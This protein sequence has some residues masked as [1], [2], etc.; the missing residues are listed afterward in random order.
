[1]SDDLVY[2]ID[3]TERIVSIEAQHNCIEAFIEHPDGRIET[4]LFPNYYWIL[5]DRPRGSGWIKMDGELEYNHIRIYQDFWEYMRWRKT[6]RGKNI[7]SV[8]CAKEAAMLH[9]G[10][11][12][13]KGMKHDEVSV[14]S[15][16]IESTSLEHTPDAKVL[17]ISNTYRQGGKTIKKLFAY[18]DY[19]NDKAMLDAWC[20]WVRE[21]DPSIIL[22]HNIYSY[23]LPYLHHVATMNNTSLKLG[24]DGRAIRFEPFQSKFRKDAS[25]FYHYHKCRIHGREVVDTMY[26]AI[27]YDIGRRYNSYGLKAIISQDGLEDPNRTHYDASQ[28]RFNYKDP[29]E[30]EKIKDYAKDDAD[31]ALKLYDIMAP[32]F[33]Y[34]TQAVPKSYQSIIESASG[35]QI[36]SIMVR[37][38]LQYGHSIPSAYETSRFQGAI[39]FGNAGIYKDVFKIDVASLYPSIMIQYNLG[40]EEKDP[41][42]HFQSLVQAFTQ[43]RL[44]NKKLAKETGEEYYKHM[45]QSQKIF[46]NSMY[47]FLGAP[48]LNFNCPKNAAFVTQTGRS[49]LKT[50]I[51]WAQDKGF[52][53]V[54]ADTDSIS[55]CREG[56]GFAEA[57]R[58]Q[59]IN[60]INELY[61]EKIKWEDDGYYQTVIVVKA[62]NYILYDGEKI[63]HK[64]SALKA[65]TKEPALQEFI[66]DIINSILEDKHD[67]TSIY[68]RY[69]REI[70]DIQ[71]IARWGTRKTITEKI[72]NPQRTNEEKIKLA[73]QGKELVE[74]DR[75]YFYFDEEENLRLIEDFDGNYNKPRL[76]EKLY[77]TALVFS[78][79][80]DI[81][82]YFINYKLKR[83]T[84]LLEEIEKNVDRERNL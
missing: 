53:I 81:K 50:A 21:V 82:K 19:R 17:L 22:G 65:S 73:I 12:Y 9:S 42:E 70:L 55:F 5:S 38:Y 36:N 51:K 83:N 28:I 35:S 49:I 15:F 67:Y 84:P 68:E 58:Q 80:I 64:G 23:D 63:K 40:D 3:K 25:M 16:D 71:D 20:T 34:V 43:K 61:P 69:V 33:F 24:R 10:I 39:S 46:I 4:K 26:L 2:G 30:W 37:S 31:D 8:Y 56:G 52:Q 45:E 7:Y 79:I 14:L 27:R 59:L 78:S 44:E 77:K 76:F 11:T 75:A 60:E 74:G 66:Q 48:G 72:L 41:K 62:K 18:D 13:F 6:L 1:M 54:N 57:E 29:V 32:P 47:G